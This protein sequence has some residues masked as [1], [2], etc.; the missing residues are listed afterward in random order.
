[1]LHQKHPI[2]HFLLIINASL[3]A[4]LRGEKNEVTFEKN[5]NFKDLLDRDRGKPRTSNTL[6]NSGYE[7]Q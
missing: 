4:T 1:M 7:V 2:Y 6:R 5:Y 3:I